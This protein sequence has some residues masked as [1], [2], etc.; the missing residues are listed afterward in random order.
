MKKDSDKDV[1]LEF[2]VVKDEGAVVRIVNNDKLDEDGNPTVILPDE[3]GK[4]T[5]PA[6]DCIDV[7]VKLADG[8]E[9]SSAYLYLSCCLQHSVCSINI[10]IIP[11]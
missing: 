8:K 1:P 5:V 6:G 4:Y 7:R 10:I 2:R 11:F 3:D 9:I